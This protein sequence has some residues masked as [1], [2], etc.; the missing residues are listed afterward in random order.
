MTH[1]DRVRLFAEYDQRR[2]QL[3]DELRAMLPELRNSIAHLCQE[4]VRSELPAVRYVGTLAAAMM[5]QLCEEL[6]EEN[7]NG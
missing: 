2:C 1:A 5:L 6:R 7:A 3:R 4:L